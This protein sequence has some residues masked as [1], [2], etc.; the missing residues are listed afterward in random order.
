MRCEISRDILADMLIGVVNVIPARTPHQLLQNILVTIAD[1]KLALAAT[2]L[3]T[4]VRKEFQLDSAAEDGTFLVSGR[5]LADV[6]REASGER[7][8]LQGKDLSLIVETGRARSILS[9]VDPTE[10]PDNPKLPEGVTV[11]LPLVTIQELFDSVAFAV[12]K[13]EGRPVMCG[14]NWEIGKTE[15]RMVA[16]DGHRLALVIRKGKFPAKAKFIIATKPFAL[17]PRGEEKVTLHLDPTRVGFVFQNTVIV[18]RLIEGQFP[19]YERVIPKGYPSRAIIGI[20]TLAAVLRRALIF[21]HPV[22]R[23]AALEFKKNRLRI[24]AETPDIGRSEEEVDCEYTGDPIRIGFNVTYLLDI[25]RRISSEKV[26]I[27]LSNPLAAGL[28]RP[29]E[30]RPDCDDTYVLMPIRLD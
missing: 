9:G 11:E 23:L 8:V 19:D 21:A 6:V 16:T 22:G 24:T 20:D 14:V 27:E 5:K 25:L 28:F 15:A 17:F 18:T 3:D 10:F 4:F 26:V 2:D 29:A 1:G 30:Q 12:S 7:V 13:D